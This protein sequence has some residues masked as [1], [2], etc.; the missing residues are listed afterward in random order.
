MGDIFDPEKRARPTASG[1][2]TKS[3]R[4]MQGINRA[5]SAGDQFR[6][7]VGTGSRPVLELF[8]QIGALMDQL[9]RGKQPG[10]APEFVKQQSM[11]NPEYYGNRPT[12]LH[13]KPME[14]TWN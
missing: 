9:I 5:R 8:L 14:E 2:Q 3:E 12:T 6:K 10:N 11:A 1:M 7:P 4:S 13:G